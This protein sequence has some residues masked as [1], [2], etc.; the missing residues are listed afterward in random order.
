MLQVVEG[1]ATDDLQLDPSVDYSSLFAAGN[2]L[3]VLPHFGG[4]LVTISEVETVASGGGISGT[5]VGSG[6][7]EEIS[8]S[9]VSTTVVPGGT[10][11]GS[12]SISAL[13]VLVGGTASDTTLMNTAKLRVR[14]GGVAFDTVL[15]DNG[16]GMIGGLKAQR[17]QSAGLCRR[18]RNW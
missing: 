3:V 2:S 4:T 15:D 16:G 6:I 17:R 11:S 18:H 8:G 1:S 7:I 12:P 14:G 5:T 13:E 10:V 9:A